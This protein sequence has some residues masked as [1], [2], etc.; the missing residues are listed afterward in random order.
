[1]WKFYII[2]ILGNIK[3]TSFVISIIFGVVLIGVGMFILF[4]L[5]EYEYDSTE[6]DIPKK[7]FKQAFIT[8][9]VFSS[10]FT[11]TPSKQFMYVT[12][13]INTTIEYIQGN[14]EVKKISGKTLQVINNKLD[15][16]L[17]EENEI[18]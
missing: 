6:L 7:I 13:S 17:K 16:Y 11:L 9:I 4:L 12:Y 8:L 1:M 15:K 18:N 14:E 10:I 5:A 2:E 3:D